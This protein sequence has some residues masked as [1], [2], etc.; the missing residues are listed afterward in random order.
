M[1][2]LIVDLYTPEIPKFNHDEFEGMYCDK[3]TSE[4]ILMPEGKMFFKMLTPEQK[5]KTFIIVRGYETYQYLF[6]LHKQGII[7][8]GLRNFNWNTIQA[9]D[10]C[11]IEGVRF[12]FFGHL[13]SK[14]FGDVYQRWQRVMSPEVEKEPI[15]QPQLAYIDTLEGCDKIFDYFKNQYKGLH[16]TDFETRGFPEYQDFENICVSFANKVYACCVDIRELCGYDFFNE[17]E[18]AVLNSQY[19]WEDGQLKTINVPTKDEVLTKRTAFNEKY[20]KFLIDTEDRYMCF[21]AE[22]EPRCCYRQTKYFPRFI[23]I[24]AYSKA[25]D[26]ISNNLKWFTQYLT[27]EPS[28]DDESEET[29][30]LLEIIF[31]K[32]QTWDAF[33]ADVQ[34]KTSDSMKYR[35]RQE[36]YDHYIQEAHTKNPSVTDEVAK[37]YANGFANQWVNIYDS[38]IK[39]TCKYWGNT[40]AS[41]KMRVMG[42]YN[43]LDSFY[44][45]NDY[46]EIQKKYKG[47]LDKA[48]RIISN[49]KLNAALIRMNGI[50]IDEGGRQRIE[51]IAKNLEASAFMA[52]TVGYIR[53]WKELT[54]NRVKSH[55]V[56]KFF[57]D[58]KKFF[59]WFTQWMTAIKA[60]NTWEDHKLEQLVARQF[61]GMIANT[62]KFYSID[63]TTRQVRADAL[64]LNE[65][66]EEQIEKKE[67]FQPRVNFDWKIEYDLFKGIA[68][69][70]KP[71]D[72]RYYGVDDTVNKVNELIKARFLP[73]INALRLSYPNVEEFKEDVAHCIQLFRHHFMYQEMEDLSFYDLMDRMDEDSGYF[74]YYCEVDTF[75]VNNVKT[76]SFAQVMER[77]DGLSENYWALDN[78]Y[79]YCL[80]ELYHLIP[81][82]WKKYSTYKEWTLNMDYDEFLEKRILPIKDL[83]ICQMDK[84]YYNLIGV[85]NVDE[86]LEVASLYG[87]WSAPLTKSTYAGWF[88][89]NFYS[90]IAV[91]KYSIDAEGLD[92][93]DTIAVME[94][95]WADPDRFWEEYEPATR[96]YFYY[97]IL[98]GGM[99]DITNMFKMGLGLDGL[100]LHDLKF[101]TALDCPFTD[102]PYHVGFGFGFGCTMMKEISTYIN[103]ITT[104]TSKLI[105]SMDDNGCTLW[106]EGTGFQD[107]YDEEN[108]YQ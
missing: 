73:E 64:K 16:A 87:K 38:R 8:I 20:R 51:H 36:C 67:D 4:N 5:R 54:K 106:E 24:W 35:T 98:G 50:F 107:R 85:N 45:Y 66:L 41:V 80:Q 13:P 53:A 31:K 57:R 10:M 62:Y 70:L 14:P 23:D 101:G 47:K 102:I 37:N 78:P 48:A 22:F 90:M 69:I 93:D 56:S 39:L 9:M 59:P 11:W 32:W 3:T 81:E 15:K 99:D 44:T 95:M 42:K 83:E 86:L 46:E 94:E 34:S 43:C 21:N 52:S 55:N 103:G 7:H 108:W 25:M 96:E 26:N 74:Y 84:Q 68:E 29:Q 49:Q 91:M 61:I 71:L 79:W 27:Y 18:S 6:G 60:D 28:W 89:I 63:P 88:L 82:T 105:S 92:V 12:S 30:H 104:K 58:T 40:W 100:G 77:A 65:W 17:D 33:I 76:E 19:V 72:I 1:N 97:P 2:R 75:G